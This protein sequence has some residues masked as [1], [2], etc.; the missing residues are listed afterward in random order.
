MSTDTATNNLNTVTRTLGYENAIDDLTAITSETPGR[1]H[2]AITSRFR[3][4][5]TN[6]ANTDGIAVEWGATQVTF[7]ADDN[8]DLSQDVDVLVGRAYDDTVTYV[9]TEGMWK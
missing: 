5:L 9:D 8:P 6:Y 3:S 4:L 2:D 7:T 1:W